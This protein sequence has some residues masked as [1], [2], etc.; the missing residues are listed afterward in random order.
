M[1]DFA[2]R[3]MSE[4]STFSRYIAGLGSTTKISSVASAHSVL[5]VSDHNACSSNCYGSRRYQHG[6]N[7]SAASSSVSNTGSTGRASGEAEPHQHYAGTQ[8]PSW[9]TYI[10]GGARSVRAHFLGK[11]LHFIALPASDIMSNTRYLFQ[12]CQKRNGPVPEELEL[13]CSASFAVQAGEAA[14]SFF[15]KVLRSR[16]Y[17]WS[18][19][20]QK[21]GKF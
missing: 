2:S 15:P 21:H 6:N 13:C 19:H 12:L 10:A 7:S 11:L 9:K 8:A 17:I 1:E 18:R 4:R 14:N 5:E 20:G 16:S 3:T